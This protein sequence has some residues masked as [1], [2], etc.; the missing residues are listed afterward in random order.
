MHQFVKVLCLD[1]SSIWMEKLIATVKEHHIVVA[2][3]TANKEY[4][5]RQ[6]DDEQAFREVERK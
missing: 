5:F 6:P 3:V 4:D 1:T 2:D